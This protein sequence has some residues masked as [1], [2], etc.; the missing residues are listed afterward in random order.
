VVRA[1]CATPQFSTPAAAER[2]RQRC[3]DVLAATFLAYR[4]LSLSE[5]VVVAGLS[6]TVDPQTTVDRCG[7]FLKIRMSLSESG[8]VGPSRQAAQGQEQEL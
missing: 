6:A 8:Q 1:H 3:K 2:N 5:L 4:P 7:S